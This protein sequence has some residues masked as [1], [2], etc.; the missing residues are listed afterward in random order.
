MSEVRGGYG[1]AIDR[2][3]AL[4]ASGTTVRTELAAGLTTFLT[5]A[6]IVAVN[7]AILGDAGMDKGA[8]FVATCLAAALGSAI[9][10]LAANYPVA[11]AP[12]MGLNAYF[13]YVIV[14]QQHFTWQAALGA[15]F[16]SGLGFLLLTLFG[17]R[18]KLVAGIPASL[19]VGITAG[20]G[21]FLAFIALKSAGL[22][23]ADPATLVTLGD[24]H[25]GPALLALLGFLVI[26]TLAA[27]RVPGALV[28]G[29][30]L[31]TALGTLTLGTKATG[32]LAPPPSLAPTLLAL[33]L[34]GALSHG[35]AE[36]VLVLFL[37]EL[38]DATGTLVGV[39][40]EAGLLAIEG[41]DRRLGRALFAD[42]LAIVAGALLGTSST[43]AYLESAAGVAAGG[44][45]GLTALTVAALFLL[46]L[47]FA[48]L[49]MVVPS[50]ATAP[51]LFFVA[52][53][54]M[55][56]L[57]AL[58]F[59]DLTE[60]VPALITAVAMP[61]TFSIANGIA[62]GLIAHVAIKV[63][64]GRARDVSLPAAVLAALFVLRYAVIAR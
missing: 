54:M 42:S 63:A 29:I 8:V 28:A 13:A 9:M 19:R 10:G 16:L 15:V 33:D 24:L 22:V 3:F 61:L 4:R 14:G 55:R 37:V 21:F 5:M 18:E 45:T 6:Y 50:C 58:P 51:A 34:R 30:A 2:F 39:A 59:D 12:G 25:R 62:F 47:V 52:C 43:T 35:L 44:R 38:L 48:P 11:L 23:V 40:G 53:L 26:A 56:G 7:P 36:I 31:V 46:T 1:G 57:R 64:A 49:V 41:A 27:R 32:L 17:L 20:I 60:A